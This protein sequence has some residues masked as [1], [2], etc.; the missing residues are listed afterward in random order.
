MRGEEFTLKRVML[1]EGPHDE[2]FFRALIREHRLTEWHITNTSD[3]NKT[4]SNS[5]FGQKLLAFTTWRGFE[6]LTDVV[7]VADND[8]DPD[9]TFKFVQD[10]IEEARKLGA[11]QYAVPDQPYIKKTGTPAVTICMMPAAG[12][13]GNL[14]ALCY[15]AAS[16]AAADVAKC[17]E[18]YSAC[19]GSDKWGSQSK[20]SKMKL[21][22]LLAGK[23]RTNPDIGLGRVWVQEP[24]LIPLND[25]C[26]SELVNHLRAYEN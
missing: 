7:V 21:R 18:Q 25:A 17:V 14:E 11:I 5:L 24:D 1:C 22:S 13:K 3:G 6:G 12:M 19:V 2:A 10:Q 15:I 4:G 9:V 8:E 26:F 20:L 16:N 23:H